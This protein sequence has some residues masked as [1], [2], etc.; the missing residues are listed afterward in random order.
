MD[1]LNLRIFLQQRMKIEGLICPDLI[2]Q[3]RQA[4]Y[5]EILFQLAYQLLK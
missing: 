1:F 5:L 2:F 3:Q 4:M